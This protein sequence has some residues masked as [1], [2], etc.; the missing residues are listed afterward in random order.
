MR[1]TQIKG[2]AALITGA[3]SSIGKAC[4][5][6]LASLGVNVIVAA[7]RIERLEALCESLP[8]EYALKALPIKMD[9]RDHQQVD[10]A[11]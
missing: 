10:D 9:V 4:A 3:S 1:I 6:Q 5:E 2:K 7:R 8:R 11:I